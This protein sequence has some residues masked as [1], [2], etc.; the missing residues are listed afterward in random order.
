MGNVPRDCLSV[1]SIEKYAEKLDLAATLPY[2]PLR[3]KVHLR[4]L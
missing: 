4:E 3:E 1:C 2:H